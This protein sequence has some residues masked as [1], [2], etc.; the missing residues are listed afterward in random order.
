MVLS[1]IDIAQDFEELLLDDQSALA[2]ELVCSKRLIYEKIF[3]EFVCIRF[4]SIEIH[5]LFMACIS[6]SLS[7]LRWK[8]M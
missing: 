2:K 6:F 7:I 5:L 1:Q 8:P 4:N 3:N